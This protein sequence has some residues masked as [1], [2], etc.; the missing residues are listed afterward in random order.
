MV[1]AAAAAKSPGSPSK[2]SFAGAPGVPK[3]VAEIQRHND[4]VKQVWEAY[5]AG[6]PT[7]TPVI[8]G[9]N[10]RYYLLGKDAPFRHVD[11]KDYTLNPDVM[12]DT[13]VR[14]QDWQRHNLVQD[15]AMGMPTEEEGWGIS[16]DFQNFCEA[17]WF[18]CELAF[19]DGQ[20][21]DTHPKFTD[22]ARKRDVIDQGDLDPFG[23]MMGDVKKY[24][25]YFRTKAESYEYKGRKV[26]RIAPKGLGTDG[27]VTVGA[28]IRGATELFTDFLEDPQYVHDLFDYITTQTI[29]RIKA[30]RKYLGQPEKQPGYWFADDSVQLISKKMY[31]EFVL[32]YHRRLK[33]ELSSTPT[34]G[35]IHLCG[36]SS[37][38]FKTIVD[39]LKIGSIDTG[40]PIDHGA[41]RRELGPSVEIYGGPHVELMRNGSAKEVYDSACAVLA[42]GV[43]EG[44]KFVLREGNNLAPETPIENIAALYQAAKQ[45]G[46]YA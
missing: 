33:E 17:G 5:R 44:G 11:F 43:R 18:G 40:F 8:I 16:V 20:V 35:S 12:F 21:P 41:V 25:E 24:Y 46:T 3:T 26:K 4:D 42:S 30:W 38:H 29:R 7:R 45:C 28:N 23:G 32:P 39:E 13:Q 19:F 14:C 34:G 37:R 9:T 2:T 36:D 1:S 27:P 6:K 22:D 31:R 10:T 15:A